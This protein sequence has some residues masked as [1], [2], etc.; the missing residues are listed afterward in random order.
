MIFNKFRIYEK[1]DLFTKEMFHKLL[2]PALIS[3]IGMAFGDMADALVVG[4]QMG[5]VGLAAISLC[6]PI[7]MFMN[8]FIYAW[9]IGGFIRYG[10]LLGEGNTEEA[11]NCFNSVMYGALIFSVTCAVLGNVF[12]P[13]LIS[14]LGASANNPEL[15]GA[16][17][18]YSRIII[19]GLPLFFLAYVSNYFLSCDGSEK[20]ATIGFTIA[21]IVDITLNIVFVLIFKFGVAG[22]ALSTVIG[23]LI[24]FIIYLVAFLDKKRTLKFKLIKPQLKEIIDC[25]KNGLST[26]VQYVWSF[27]F[28]LAA[29]NVLIRESGENAVA[30]FDMLQNASYLIVYIFEAVEKAIQP[31]ISTYVGECNVQGIN[32]C[33]K[34]SLFEGSV[35]GLIVSMVIALFAGLVCK[36][37]GLDTP[38]LLEMGNNALRIYCVSTLFA[39]FNMIIAAYE[40]AVYK[41]KMAYI[42]TSLRGGII[43]IPCMILFSLG[44]IENFWWIYA[45]TETVTF[46]VFF[47]VRKVMH[48]KDMFTGM[49]VFE[50]IIRSRNEDLNKL[51]GEVEEYCDIHDIEPKKAYMVNMAVEELLVVIMKFA[52]KYREN[53]FVKLTILKR[54]DDVEIHIR[55]NAGRF[56]PFTVQTKKV[57]D[58]DEDA[59]DT[60]GIMMLKKKSKEL[61]YR[62]YQGF[63]NVVVKL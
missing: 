45:V 54:N 61:Y 17:M 2:V 48:E 23:Q 55:D 43:L 4:N 50:K 29:N 1:E 39:G 15:Y 19:T 8:V 30:V 33:K 14:M 32:Y 42:I 16:T 40:Q 53:G 28:I 36:M 27:I 47:I 57:S 6:L 56:N 59:I 58:M 38:E 12:M 31:I 24:A 51:L 62:N 10:R 9:G 35:L 52:F 44:S 60:M 25:F 3:S 63:N 11:I 20:W 21:N 49:D 34:I 5:A 7:F 41:E 22:A 13:E 37:F 18:N 46:V 26:S